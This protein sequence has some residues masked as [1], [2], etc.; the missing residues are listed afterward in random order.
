MLQIGVIVYGVFISLHDIGDVAASF[1]GF[2]RGGDRS[3]LGASE[4]GM[5]EGEVSPTA[6]PMKLK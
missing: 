4:G 1:L 3:H 2:S 5:P 6:K